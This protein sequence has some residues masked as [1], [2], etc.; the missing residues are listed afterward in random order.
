MAYKHA[1]PDEDTAFKA[2]ARDEH[3]QFGVMTKTHQIT[4]SL[5]D[6]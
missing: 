5:F 6:I 1:L 4:W 3:E 2:Q